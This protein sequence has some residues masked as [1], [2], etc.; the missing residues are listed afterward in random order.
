MDTETKNY[1]NILL[2]EDDL[3]D[4]QLTLAAL[5]EHNL[6]NAVFVVNDGAE[7]LD[8]LFRRGKF[9][10]RAAGDPV[11]VLLDNKM[12]KVGGLE[13]L[14][15]IKA[16]A[17][18]RTIPVVALT[19]S[20]E[21][22]DLVEFYKHGVNAYVVKPVDFND[23]IAAVKKLGVFWAAVNEA[24]FASANELTTIQDARSVLLAEK[25]ST[26]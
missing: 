8:Y 25:E 11:V 21:T 5:E 20:R 16:D 1:K 18:L 9:K 10:D 26:K 17:R 6:A 24:P 12:P 23:F 15:T 22:P 7:A 2:V 4:V 13:V 3:R 14:K 19:S